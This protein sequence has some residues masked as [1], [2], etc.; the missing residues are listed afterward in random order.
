MNHQYGRIGHWTSLQIYT[1]AGAT[2]LHREPHTQSKARA[3]LHPPAVS[4]RRFC[5][6][7][8]VIFL[9]WQ[10]ELD[11]IL[12]QPDRWVS[13]TRRTHQPVCSRPDLLEP[14]VP[15]RNHFNLSITV[16]KR[17]GIDPMS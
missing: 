7:D 12:R 4:F 14:Y 6:T 13:I 5:D 11:P 1:S 10:D 3:R 8:H 16:V 2:E 9:S 15:Q 17:C